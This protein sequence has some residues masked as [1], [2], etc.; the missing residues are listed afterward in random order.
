MAK[1]EFK[2]SREPSIEDQATRL[3]FKKLLVI[4]LGLG[5]A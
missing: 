5:S 2:L 3:S 4:F 1:D